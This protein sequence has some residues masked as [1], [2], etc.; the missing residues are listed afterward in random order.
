[1]E[2]LYPTQ[3]FI[4]TEKPL[5]YIQMKEMV[6]GHSVLLKL[7]F[8][9]HLIITHPTITDMKSKYK[10]YWSNTAKTWN[11]LSDGLLPNPQCTP[12]VIAYAETSFA[13]LSLPPKADADFKLD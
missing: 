11:A 12:R 9:F 8:I 10:L 5:Q 6:F 3:Q 7:F 4:Y 2:F 13:M 1:M